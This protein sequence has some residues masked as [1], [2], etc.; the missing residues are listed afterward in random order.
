VREEAFFHA[1]EKD[2]WELEALGGVEGHEGDASFCGVTVGV[3]DESGMV[4]KF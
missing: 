4:E 3:G 2:E 1:S